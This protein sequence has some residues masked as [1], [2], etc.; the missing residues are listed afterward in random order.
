MGEPHPSWR[1]SK[2]GMNCSARGEENRLELPVPKAHAGTTP[3]AGGKQDVSLTDNFCAA[4]YLQK[5]EHPEHPAK[6]QRAREM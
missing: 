1:P 5:D 2:S 6:A 3:P 4:S